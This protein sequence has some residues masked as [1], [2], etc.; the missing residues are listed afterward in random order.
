MLEKKKDLRIKDFILDLQKEFLGNFT[1]NKTIEFNKNI[2]KI[3]EMFK[4]ATNTLKIR[5][6]ELIGNIKLKNDKI[7]KL[8]LEVSDKFDNY[9]SLNSSISK[10]DGIKQ[11]F[12][13]KIIY[14]KFRFISKE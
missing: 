5:N 2:N 8:K 11:N 14:I 9:K 6:K 7:N 1:S 10:L 3:I 4:N 13:S 12:K